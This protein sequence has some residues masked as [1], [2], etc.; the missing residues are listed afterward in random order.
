MSP[1]VRFTGRWAAFWTLGRVGE[2][3]RVMTLYG[4]SRRLIFW[5]LDLRYFGVSPT[6]ARN[7][8]GEPIPQSSPFGR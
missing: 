2:V 4:P 3:E 5:K 6:A 7:A 1:Q 8:N